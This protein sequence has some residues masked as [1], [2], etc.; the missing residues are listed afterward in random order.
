MIFLRSQIHGTARRLAIKRI[1]PGDFEYDLLSH[2]Y[3]RVN[4]L[5]LEYQCKVSHFF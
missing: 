5:H 1:C 3:G 2:Q 4:G